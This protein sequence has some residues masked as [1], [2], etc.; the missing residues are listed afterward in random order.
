MVEDPTAKFMYT[1]NLNDG[2]ITGYSFTSTEGTLSDLARGSPFT[3]GDIGL[4]CLALSNS[5]D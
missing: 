5:V 3:T 4:A 2:T 1:S